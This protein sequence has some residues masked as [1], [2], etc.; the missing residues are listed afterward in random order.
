MWV[1]LTF[2]KFA[3]ADL[4]DARKLYNSPFVSGVIRQQKGY[5]FHYWLESAENPGEVVSLT[6]WDTRE[7]AE[8]YEQSG[9]YNE[10]G[11]RFRRWFNTRRELRSYAIRE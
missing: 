4:D 1:R 2:S 6:A 5:R 7:D 3:P 9:V 11:E 8:A 10:L